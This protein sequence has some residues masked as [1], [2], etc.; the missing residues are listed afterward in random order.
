MQSQNLFIERNRFHV[1]FDSGYDIKGKIH[2]GKS[3]DGLIPS[4][5]LAHSP[6]STKAIILSQ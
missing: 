3:A 2:L 5:S 6:Y 1:R 4:T